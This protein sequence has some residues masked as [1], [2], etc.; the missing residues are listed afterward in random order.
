MNTWLHNQRQHFGGCHIASVNS[1]IGFAKEHGAAF[2][3][4]CISLI[5]FFGFD[6]LIIGHELPTI[7]SIV[8]TA[9]AFPVTFFAFI[10]QTQWS[11]F[12]TQKEVSRCRQNLFAPMA[13]TCFS[14]VVCIDVHCPNSTRRSPHKE[15][16]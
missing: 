10:R 5:A 12:V 8:T 2:V 1:L 15:H 9:L 3:S 14:S 4:F 7:W 6:L 13:L 16:P 11:G